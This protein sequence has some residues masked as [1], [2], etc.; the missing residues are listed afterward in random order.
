MT[1]LLAGK[2]APDFELLTDAGT[3]LTLASLRGNW[4]VLFFYPQDDT[5]G[6][7]IENIEFSV[8]APQFS[9]LGIKLVGISP[10]SV[11]DHCSFRAK[12]N[13]GVTLLADPDKKAVNAY[14]LWQAKK[15]YGRDYIGLVRSTFLIDPAGKVA[16]Y[17]K[18]TR[19][20][21]HAQ[22]VLDT[23]KSLL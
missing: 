4:T 19:I 8:L 20:K 1:D 2:T 18:V 10:D 7:T 12:Y 22:K 11:A 9:E 17:W 15:L 21:G 6:C 14:G 5:E 13:L 3:P 16:M 23:A